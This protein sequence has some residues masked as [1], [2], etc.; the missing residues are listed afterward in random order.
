MSCLDREV[1]LKYL[2][3]ELPNAEEQAVR[4]HLDVCSKCQ[5][6]LEEVT[7]D[8]ADLRSAISELEP[9]SIPV[10]VF[11]PSPLKSASTTGVSSRSTRSR[12]TP[13][14]WIR[15]VASLAAAAAVVIVTLP[16]FEYENDQTNS[17]SPEEIAFEQGYLHVNPNTAFHNRQLVITIIDTEKNLSEQVVTSTEQPNS[18]PNR[19]SFDQSEQNS[20]M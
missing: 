13:T 20:S 6:M 3:R 1:I 4:E 16:W 18:T 14:Y 19:P 15:L 8:I 9:E 5:E 7:G 12:L 10:P 11:D 17:T 2:D